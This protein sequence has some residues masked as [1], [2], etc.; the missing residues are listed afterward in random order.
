MQADNRTGETRGGSIGDSFSVTGTG[1]GEQSELYLVKH[2]AHL[3]LSLD[4]AYKPP[5]PLQI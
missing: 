5:L 4:A 2:E 1:S 3:F